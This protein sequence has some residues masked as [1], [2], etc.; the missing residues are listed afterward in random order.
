MKG[1][2]LDDNDV[3]KLDASENPTETTTST[4]NEVIQAIWIGF[5]YW[6]K[7]KRRINNVSSFAKIFTYGVHGQVLRSSGGG[8]QSGV[9]R[10]HLEFIPDKPEDEDEPQQETAL[11]LPSQVESPLDDLRAEL[12]NNE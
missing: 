4:H 3:V 8:W 2:N 6:L 9:I 1:F 7:E 12:F 5:Y 11:L 10:V